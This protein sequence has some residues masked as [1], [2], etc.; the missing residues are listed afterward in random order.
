MES[1]DSLV[2][3]LVQTGPGVFPAFSTK[4]IAAVSQGKNDPCAVLNTHPNLA[5]PILSY[6][7]KFTFTY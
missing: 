7:V 4:N 6:W 5:P 3:I 2:S 1:R